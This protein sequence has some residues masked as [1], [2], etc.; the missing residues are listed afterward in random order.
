MKLYWHP[1]MQVM[2]KVVL[3]PPT[4]TTLKVQLTFPP[5]LKS[6][7]QGIEFD[8]ATKLSKSVH[9]A[10]GNS[11]PPNEGRQTYVFE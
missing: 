7:L 9:C 2:Y 3:V 8:H 5:F 11:C 4:A 1:A 6:T 10:T